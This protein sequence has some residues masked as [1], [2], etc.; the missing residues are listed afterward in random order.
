MK[1]TSHTAVI[2][3]VLMANDGA[4][5]SA[6]SAHHEVGVIATEKTAKK[7]STKNGENCLP[8]GVTSD[9][10]VQCVSEPI[11]HPLQVGARRKWETRLQ[12][13]GYRGNQVGCT[14]ETLD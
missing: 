7:L 13:D 1:A 12:N 4:A 14:E 6:T 2:R 3:I 9:T 10:R 5:V 11:R 8:C